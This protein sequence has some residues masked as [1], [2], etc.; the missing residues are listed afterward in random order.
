MKYLAFFIIAFL[1]SCL[2]GTEVNLESDHII[3]NN[4]FV[5]SCD[6]GL[7]VIEKD[8]N[9]GSSFEII[10]MKSNSIVYSGK[11]IFDK[12]RYFST[13]VSSDG[14]FIFQYNV[15][16]KKGALFSLK[17]GEKLRSFS[18]KDRLRPAGGVSVFQGNIILYN[19]VY[20]LYIESIRDS[21]LNVSRIN[22]HTHSYN[23]STFTPDH[24][25]SKIYILYPN[26]ENEIIIESIDVENLES[27]W[28]TKLLDIKGG[29][30]KLPDPHFSVS[31]KFIHFGYKNHIITIDKELGTIV[32]QKLLEDS[33]VI[34]S[35]DSEGKTHF[36]AQKKNES[37]YAVS[38]SQSEEE[39]T[40]LCNIKTPLLEL[41]PT[42]NRANDIICFDQENVIY[43][44]NVLDVKKDDRRSFSDKKK[45]VKD[46]PINRSFQFEFK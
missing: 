37:I 3:A 9:K 27:L 1:F 40:K 46:V 4:D 2:N 26:N 5:K 7:C 13:F 17:S 39:I 35:F 18:F 45:F 41:C 16:L 42:F 10:D 24:D 23:L 19:D 31:N 21:S 22:K 38:L 28:R 34:G 6:N 14:E 33:H 8:K 20:G 29:D 15:L 32:M 25:K 11:Y 44:D 43:I 12:D 36:I 30:P